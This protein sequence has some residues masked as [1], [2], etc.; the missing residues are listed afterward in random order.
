[1]LICLCSKNDEQDVAAVF[2]HRPEMP[3][4]RKQIIAWR[5]NWRPKSKNIRALADT[6]GLGLDSFVVIYDSPLDCAE[7]RAACPDVLTLQLPADPE[8]IPAFLA[9][10]WAFDR[11]RTTGGDRQRTALYR[12]QA[13]RERYRQ[14][15]L[16]L[17][18][19]LAGLGLQ[20]AIA[21]PEPA[22][23]ERVA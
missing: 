15:T 22:Q 8:G 6:L 18:D 19:F 16:S 9:H 10:C 20:I 12:Q 2:E 5:I 13:E 17:G 7:L 1:M 21:A 23:L 4:R 11:P 14:E 3:L